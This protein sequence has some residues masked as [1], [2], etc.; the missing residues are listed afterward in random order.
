MAEEPEVDK[1][2]EVAVGDVVPEASVTVIEEE[3]LAVVDEVVAEAPSVEEPV[4]EE[5]PVVEEVPTV[6]APAEEKTE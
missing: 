5:P 6:E 2:K 4:A 3:V 1:V